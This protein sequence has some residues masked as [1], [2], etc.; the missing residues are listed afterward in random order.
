LRRTDRLQE[1][2]GGR[3]HLAFSIGVAMASSHESLTEKE[4]ETLRLIARGH[5]AKSAAR[6]LD[7]SV[8]TVN[9]RLRNSRRKMDV[10]SSREAARTLL[11]LE[12]NS[13]EQAPKNLAYKEIGG[14]NAPAFTEP[15]SIV[16]QGRR[17]ARW[18]GGIA[19]MSLATLALVVT[20][21]APLIPEDLSPHTVTANLTA[22]DA[23][24]EEAART[25]LALV[26]ASDWQASYEAA[27]AAFREPN[28]VAEWQA[29]SE[30]VRTPLGSVMSREA[31][32]TE[33][34][35]APP[36]GFLLVRFLTKFENGSTAIE[37]VT[38]EEEVGGLKVVGYLIE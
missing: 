6:E 1:I 13:K 37:H 29:A 26:D 27:G 30:Q 24:P 34:V 31:I 22:T 32:K 4:K 9:E 10:T 18:I 8:H 3:E 16:D 28:T 14:E 21:S 35:N 20:L 5:D 7:I 11:E 25:W 15:A 2:W 19:V 23:A 36:N 17:W 33:F 38:L 12:A